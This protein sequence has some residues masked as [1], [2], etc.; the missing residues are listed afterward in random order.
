MYIISRATLLGMKIIWEDGILPTESYI[1][2]TTLDSY[3]HF[4]KPESYRQNLTYGILP[5]ESYRHNFKIGIFLLASLLFEHVG[6]TYLY[7]EYIKSRNIEFVVGKI[8]I[9]CR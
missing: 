3:R 9:W 4:L 6:W 1:N 5:T 2:E 8:P 7:A